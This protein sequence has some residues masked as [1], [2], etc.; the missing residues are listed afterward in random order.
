MRL[1]ASLNRIVLGTNQ[2]DVLDTFVKETIQESARV[3][4]RAALEIIPS[5]SGASRATLQSL[6]S[7]V[8]EHV[9]IDIKN[10]APDRIGLGRLFSRGGIERKALGNWEFFYESQL[11]Y[12][13][14]NETRKV[15]PRTYGLR[16]KLIAPTPYKF[17][18]AGNAAVEAYLK[19]VK[20]PLLPLKGERI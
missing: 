17:R 15:A 5:W 8:G 14:A 9:A 4:V 3:W 7:A 12:L 6:A 13:I 11:E 1:R 16:G 20:V 19:T 10:N 2:V 18:E